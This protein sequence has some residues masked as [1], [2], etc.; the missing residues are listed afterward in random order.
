MSTRSPTA[1]PTR[2]A[3]SRPI[4]SKTFTVTTVVET[5]TDTELEG[6]VAATL[7]VRLTGTPSF[8]SFIPNV[9]RD[10][11]ASTTATVTS[12]AGAATLTVSDGSATHTGKLVNGTHALAQPLQVRSGAGAFAALGGAAA[13]T[14]LLALGDPVSG[15]EVPVEF[16]Q[17]IGERDPLRTGRYAKTLTFTLSTTTP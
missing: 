5:E 1:R 9:A 4:G 17:S 2:P 7:A 15:E 3:T 13:P 12:T 6:S 14:T 10:Y 16:K 8:G 11:T